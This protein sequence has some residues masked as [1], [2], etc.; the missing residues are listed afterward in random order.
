MV[1]TAIIG[2]VDLLTQGDILGLLGVYGY[3]ACI[4]IM[5]HLLRRRLK[6]PRKLVHILTGGIVFFWW[7]FDTQWVMAG[8]AALP[9]V[10]I[11]ILMTPISP[12][13][14]LRES[15]LGTISSKGHEYGL[16]MY[17]ISWTL[18]AFFMFDDLFAASVAIAAMSFGDGMGEVIGRRYGRHE[19][20]SHR[21]IE[22]SLAVLLSSFVAIV[23]IALFYFN[24]IGYSG[25][26]QPSMLLPFAFGVASFI[27][28][29]EAV[30]PGKVDNLVLPLVVGGFLHIMGV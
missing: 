22:G 28:I 9:F 30:T 17:A 25:G 13:K 24:V 14:R 29:L 5:S 15:S 1:A 6:N 18:I 8:L 20:I 12:I 2:V 23:V 4:L 7:S 27:T 21:T 11:L 26:S 3:V 19:L 16:V 10:P